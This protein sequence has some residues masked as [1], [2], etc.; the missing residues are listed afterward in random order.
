[1]WPPRAT[2]RL[3][4]SV[5]TERTGVILWVHPSR[6]SLADVAGMLVKN[7]RDDRAAGLSAGGSGRYG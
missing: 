5:G 1:M 4:G 6:L 2:S 7:E 3:K